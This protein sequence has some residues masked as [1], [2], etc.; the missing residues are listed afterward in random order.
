[1]KNAKYLHSNYK[2]FISHFR[3]Y[4][5]RILLSFVS[6]IGWL[7]VYGLCSTILIKVKGEEVLENYYK[8]GKR[9]IFTFWHDS[10][11]FFVYYYRNRNINVLVSE[12]KDGEYI[13][14]TIEKLGF[15]S[16]RGSSSRGGLKGLLKMINALKEGYDAGI[17]PDGP[18]GPRHV[19]KEGVLLLSQRTG[20]PIIPISF[21]SRKGK[22]FKSWDKFFMPFPFSRGMLIY[23]N[24]IEIPQ[25]CSTEELKKYQ[26]MVEKELNRIW[27]ECR[28]GYYP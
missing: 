18:R 25:N 19:L 16:L 21:S 3:I 23:G 14:R 17:T 6:G 11:L 27:E 2:K 10:Q 13:T 12:S 24:P 15:R 4:K 26:I 20:C 7:I 5:D 8:K 9:V 28:G 1:M 22:Y